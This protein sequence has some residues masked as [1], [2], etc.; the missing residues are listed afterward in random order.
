MSVICYIC[1]RCVHVH[2]LIIEHIT[3][4]CYGMLYSDSV[5]IP[6]CCSLRQSSHSAHPYLVLSLFCLSPLHPLPFLNVIIMLLHCVISSMYCKVV[7]VYD[8]HVYL[9]KDLLRIICTVLLC[10][11]LLITQSPLQPD[12]T[13]VQGTN[14]QRSSKT[15]EIQVDSIFCTISYYYEMIF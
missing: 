6:T 11:F 5:L 15:C 7:T 12:T 14:D 4:M 1:L 2:I 3:C 9:I 10:D 13:L 8:I